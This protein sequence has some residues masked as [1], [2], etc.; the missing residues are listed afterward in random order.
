MTRFKTQSSYEK[1]R[2]QMKHFLKEA[3]KNAYARNLQLPP[4]VFLID[5]GDNISEEHSDI[6]RKALEMVSLEKE[7]KV[8]QA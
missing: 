2:N 4:A 7:N 6:V 3:F 1:I 8:Y 5:G